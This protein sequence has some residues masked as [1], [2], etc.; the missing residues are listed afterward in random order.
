MHPFT[1]TRGNHQMLTLEGT[2]EG[3]D[4]RLRKLRL[5]SDL[6]DADSNLIRKSTSTDRYIRHV[7][8]ADSA[9]PPLTQQPVRVLLPASVLTRSPGRRRRQNAQPRH[10]RHL[11]N[12]PHQ[13]EHPSTPSNCGNVNERARAEPISSRRRTDLDAELNRSRRGERPISTRVATDLGEGGRGKHLG[14]GG[15]VPV[16]DSSAGGVVFLRVAVF[17]AVLVDVFRAVVVF[18]AAFLVVVFFAAVLRVVRFL[19]G[20]LARFSASSS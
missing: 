8:K 16:Q 13:G 17:W 15:H 20:P 14:S 7:A 10:L 6:A 9:D 18:L 2:H 1:D 4:R 12:R 5:F 3:R 11:I 19:A